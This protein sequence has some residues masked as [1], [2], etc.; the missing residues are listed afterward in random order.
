MSS[1]L[2]RV[3]SSANGLSKLSS[4]DNP[5]L[6]HR[7]RRGVQFELDF[8]DWLL[9]VDTVL[10]SENGRAFESGVDRLYNA[11]SG[12]GGSGL[13][14]RMEEVVEEVEAAESEEDARE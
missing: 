13:W 8:G 3:A 7:D 6:Q 11:G 5:G 14:S 12:S 2:A 4:S 10:A 9:K 1:C